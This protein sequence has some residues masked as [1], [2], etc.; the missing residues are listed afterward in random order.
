[1]RTHAIYH[2]KRIYDAIAEGNKAEAG[3][4]M[5]DHL[6][7]TENDM[8]T[9]VHDPSESLLS[10]RAGDGLPASRSKRSERSM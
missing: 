1:V 3:A 9:Y 7:Q 6:T 4:A 5:R 8:D 2:H 10:I